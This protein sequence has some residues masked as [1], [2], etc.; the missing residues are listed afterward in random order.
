MG[1]NAVQSEM[2]FWH[3]SPRFS[4]ATNEAKVS[5]NSSMPL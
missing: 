5:Q 4:I 3:I 1:R 2:A